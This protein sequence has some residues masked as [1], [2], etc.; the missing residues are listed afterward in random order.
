[1]TSYWGPILIF[2]HQLWQPTSDRRHTGNA[3]TATSLYV[4]ISL[5]LGRTLVIDISLTL[6]FDVNP[7]F[8]SKQKQ[9]PHNVGVQRQS[10]VICACWVVALWSETIFT[11]VYCQEPKGIILYSLYLY[12]DCFFFF[13]E[14]IL[15][16][17]ENNYWHQ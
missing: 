2:I 3:H 15:K 9:M 7:M 12:F 1:M 13:D 16:N 4:I 11:S 5:I 17:A 8:I 14:D 6:S 10:D